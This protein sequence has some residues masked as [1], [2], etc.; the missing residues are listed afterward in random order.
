MP[1]AEEFLQNTQSSHG[2]DSPA[3]T[4]LRRIGPVLF[5]ADAD[6]GQFGCLYG[7]IAETAELHFCESTLNLF[8]NGKNM[9]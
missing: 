3:M 9:I 6:F 4:V 8:T 2:Q 5:T 1:P 7:F